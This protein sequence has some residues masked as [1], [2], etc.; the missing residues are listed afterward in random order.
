MTGA[1]G[2]SRGGATAAGARNRAADLAGKALRIIDRLCAIGFLGF[3]LW[4]V[5]DLWAR[6]AVHGWAVL[7]LA[8]PVVVSTLLL[9]P[10]VFGRGGDL[11]RPTWPWRWRKPR[12]KGARSRRVQP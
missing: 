6:A 3:S 11:L 8:I 9:V 5:W 10:S 12:Q 2:A 7:V 1:G 4:L